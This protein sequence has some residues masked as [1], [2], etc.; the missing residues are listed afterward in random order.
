MSKIVVSPK[1]KDALKKFLIEHKKVDLVTAYLHYLEHAHNLHPVVFVPERAVYCNRDQALQILE[2][3]NKLWRETEIKISFEKGS[4]N[5]E[6][7][8]IYICPFSGKVFG[9]NTHPNPQDAIYDWVSKCAENKELV[10]G[11]RSKRFHICEDLEVIKNYI[12]P[13]AKTIT[14]SVFASAINGKL[15]SNK[16]AVLQDCIQ[17]YFKPMTLVEVQGQNRY[18]MHSSLLEILQ[19]HLDEERIEQFVEALSHDISF[20]SYLEEWVSEED[21]EA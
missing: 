2:S 8:K 10:G 20:K 19:V 7:K 14:K 16:Q 6:T 11:L 12:T 1:A 15:F 18:Q 21:D 3:E 9:D 17:H 13:L 4:V 5:A